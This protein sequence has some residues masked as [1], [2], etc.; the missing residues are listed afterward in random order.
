METIEE[1]PEQQPRKR[2][3]WLTAFLILMLIANPFTAFTYVTNPDPILQAYP[4]MTIEIVY[5]LGLLTTLNVVLA[6]GMWMWKKWG[7]FGFYGITLVAFVINIYVG[8]GIMGSLT[9]LV[10]AVI[11]YLTTRG[12]MAHFS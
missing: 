3:G 1:L 5:F 10:G 2:G 11:I 8:L 6:I 9:G 12:R 4:K 7:I